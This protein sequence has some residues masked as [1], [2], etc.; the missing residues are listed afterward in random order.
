MSL[1]EQEVECGTSYIP[2]TDDFVTIKQH[3]VAEPHEEEELRV[4]QEVSVPNLTFETNRPKEIDESRKSTVAAGYDADRFHER[5]Q[6][7]TNGN[8]ENSLHDAEQGTELTAMVNLS[9]HEVDYESAP[10]EQSLVQGGNFYSTGINYYGQV[11]NHGQKYPALSGSFLYEEMTPQ[12]TPALEQNYS[13]H[14]QNGNDISGNG[15][16]TIISSIGSGYFDTPNIADFLPIGDNLWNPKVPPLKLPGEEAVS[17]NKLYSLQSK[18]TY[19]TSLSFLKSCGRKN[20]KSSGVSSCSDDAVTTAIKRENAC[21]RERTRMRQM[22]RA[23]DTLRAKLPFCKPRG[24]KMSKIEALRSAIR[25]IAHLKNI[26]DADS[27]SVGSEQ[28]QFVPHRESGNNNTGSNYNC[29]YRNYSTF[30]YTE[31]NTLHYFPGNQ[32]PEPY[33]E[34]E[35]QESNDFED[36]QL[37]SENRNDHSIE[38]SQGIPCFCEDANCNDKCSQRQEDN[39]VQIESNIAQ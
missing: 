39:S 4:S 17:S 22:N 27:D 6:S 15:N 5:D 35:Y 8:R 16:S 13:S 9:H 7:I 26:L 33:Y 2:T 18:S 24:R 28:Y 3:D 21:S 37:V 1:T 12:G 25:Y 14:Y 19:S 29:D 34:E 11:V 30:D 20:K 31:V 36:E 32:Y 10:F 23:F 38:S